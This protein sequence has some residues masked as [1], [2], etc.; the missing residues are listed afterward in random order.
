[1]DNQYKQFKLIK[2]H[3]N[4]VFG[5]K[6]KEYLHSV[7]SSTPG[8]P[9]YK[10]KMNAMKEEQQLE[11]DGIKAELDYKVKTD[12]N[13]KSAM[14]AN[15]LKEI[16]LKQA[17]IDQQYAGLD[18]IDPKQFMADDVVKVDPT[19]QSKLMQDF[20]KANQQ[21]TKDSN[22]YEKSMSIVENYKKNVQN[23]L[24]KEY[25]KP[26]PFW[27][28]DRERERIKKEREEALNAGVDMNKAPDSVKKASKF[29]Q[30]FDPNET[31]EFVTTLEDALKG[32]DTVDEVDKAIYGTKVEKGGLDI[33]KFK[34]A[35]ADALKSVKDSGLS[36]ED[37]AIREKALIRKFNEVWQ[38]QQAQVAKAQNTL[39]DMEVWKD[40]E[41][42]KSGLKIEEYGEQYILDAALAKVKAEYG[43]KNQYS[44]NDVTSLLKDMGVEH[45]SA[46]L[47]TKVK[48]V[49]NKTGNLPSNV[50]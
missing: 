45:I 41:S 43:V 32:K 17:K 46:D 27:V 22:K 25:D 34:K 16:E 23:K 1:L 24:K 3:Q 21:Y 40:Q 15:D 35:R 28:P 14:Y 18:P 30:Y 37:A 31:P 49:L 26:I 8:T 48:K 19:K 42:F 33:E 9:E 13:Y 50:R 11:L 38:N 29:L 39:A 44:A 2:D 7:A 5:L 47:V 12:P 36:A 20:E 10:A 6:Q 4:N